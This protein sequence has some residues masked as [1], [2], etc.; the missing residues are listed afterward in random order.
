M[1]T[2]YLLRLGTIK[3]KSGVLEA[4]KHNKRTLQAERGAS[5]NIDAASTSL[6]YCLTAN[7]TPQNIAN[8]AYAQMAYAGIVQPRK[9]GVMAV[10]VI[11]S[12]PIDRHRQDT[13]PFFVDCLAWVK[14][15][16][17][18]ELLSFDIHLDESAPH[19]HAVILPLID[20]KMQ[21][22]WL[23]G[24]TGNLN[25]L[26]N[27]FHNEVARNYGLS[28]NSK[29]LTSEQKQTIEAQVLWRL[30]PDPVMKSQIW[31]CVRDVIHSD[32]V[33]FAQLLSI[34][35]A[36]AQRGKVKSFVDY[37]RARGKGSF[38]R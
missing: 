11:F 13:K 17:A 24:N 25:R 19:A 6:N 4:L 1:A 2:S 12:L 18:G 26:R 32:P 36:Q 27:L 22:N 15:H 31:A 30:K 9:N 38:A 3:G 5:A 20:G 7:D 34:Q 14:L 29:R 8:H 35:T 33:P 28:R 37:A 21:G 16:L 23:M 10:E